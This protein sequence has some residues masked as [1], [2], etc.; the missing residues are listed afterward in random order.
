MKRRKLPLALTSVTILILI[1][2]VGV[3]FGN[4]S[5]TPAPPVA[6]RIVP[7]AEPVIEPTATPT[8]EPVVEPTQEP[9]SSPVSDVPVAGEPCPAWVHDQYMATGP[10]GKQ[11]PTWHPSVDSQYG[12]TFGHEHGDNPHGNSALQGRQVVFGYLEQ[13]HGMAM[14][15]SGYKVFA[16]DGVQSSNGP[17]HNGASVVMVLHQGTSGA[18]RF[19]LPH[20]DVEMHYLNPNDGREAH[21]YMLAPFGELLVGCGANDP[22]MVLQLQQT[23]HPGA[24]QISADK[25]FDAP[26][27]P[28]EDWITALYIGVDASGNWKAYMDPHFA[29]FE[30]NT[31]C[32]VEN[33]GCTLGYSDERAGTGADPGGTDAEF[34]GTKREA[35]LNQVWFHN[36]GGSTTVWTDVHGRLVEANSP[37]A[38]PQYI[39]ALDDRQLVESTAFGEA[40]DHDPDGS[41]HAPN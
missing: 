25:C 31:F 13:F 11:Y 19:T 14:P 28:Y 8:A 6:E 33:N 30:P 1:G 23:D 4:R 17:S 39:A 34:K 38:I 10:D 5:V 24:R 3:Y 21:V 41:V 2:M 26:N 40:N 22:G 20:H 29:I 36:A 27:I 9:S 12:C 37:G 35:Y 16:W 15:H 7:T 18:G 32:I